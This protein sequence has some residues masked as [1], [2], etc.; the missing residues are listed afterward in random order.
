MFV[1]RLPVPQRSTGTPIAI[2]S[3]ILFCVPR[4]I[5][6]GA[7]VSAARSGRTLEV[8]STE[9]VLQVYTADALGR[10]TT[11]DL[12]KNG[13]PHR[14]RAGLCLEPQQYPNAPNCPG[15][16][17]NTVEPGRPY[18]GRTRYRFGLMA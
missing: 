11:P 13:V 9:P 7:T 4:A 8:W 16:P 12:G 17:Q 14:P 1:S 10:S 18:T 2:D 6:S 15:F 5:S 3:R